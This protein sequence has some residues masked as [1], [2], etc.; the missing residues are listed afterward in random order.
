MAATEMAAC[1]RMFDG[2]L[3]P[4]QPQVLQRV[5]QLAVVVALACLGT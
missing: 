5:R 1:R 4:Q 2:S 3:K